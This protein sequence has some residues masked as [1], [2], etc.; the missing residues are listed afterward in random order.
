MLLKNPELALASYKFKNPPAAR[1]MPK[2]RRSVDKIVDEAIEKGTPCDKVLWVL[3]SP[4]RITPA[5]EGE[6]KAFGWWDESW[7]YETSPVAMYVVRFKNGRVVKKMS[8]A[9]WNG[10][11]PGGK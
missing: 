10:E 7:L 5:T 6:R 11:R 4:D 3:G 2:Q 9:D 8:C 1:E